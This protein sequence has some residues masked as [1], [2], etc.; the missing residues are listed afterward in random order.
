VD[1]A[2]VWKCHEAN[3]EMDGGNPPVERDILVTCRT[4]LRGEHADQL[5]YMC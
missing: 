1:G 3:K 4:I 2:S 5:R